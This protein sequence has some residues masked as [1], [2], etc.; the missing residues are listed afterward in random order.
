[1][2]ERYRPAFE[3]FIP[4]LSVLVN[5]IYWTPDYPRLVTKKYLRQYWEEHDSPRLTVIGDISCDVEGAIECTLYAT[6]PGAPVYVYDPIEMTAA[7]GLKGRGVVVMATDNLPAELSLESSLFFSKA[8]SPYVPA[9]AMADYSGDFEMCD[10]PYPIK[11]G[12]ILYRGKLTPEFAYME[13]F[14]KP[15]MEE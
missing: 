12:V 5:C 15:N 4:Y 2:P 8:L 13:K 10:L 9:I 7:E 1:M 3:S 6:N 11:R 14:V